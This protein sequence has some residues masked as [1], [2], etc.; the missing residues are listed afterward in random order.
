MEEDGYI[1]VEQRQKAEEELDQVQ[2]AARTS[3]FAAPHFV[4]FVK[5]ILVD[6]Y[7]EEMVENG[8][9]KVT[10][11][12]DLDLQ[13]EAEKIVAEE[14]EKVV[15]LN[16][17]NGAVIVLEPESGE[18]LAM[19]G[20]RDYNEPNF[21]KVNVVTQGLRQPGSAIK[22]LLMYCSEKGYTPPIFLDTRTEFTLRKTYI[23]V[24][25]D[26]KYHGRF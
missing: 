15:D 14:I 5:Q 11:T 24:N 8:G 21:G 4:M 2:F 18:I 12:L 20:S 16:I 9:L 10:T 7:G 22:R 3:D 13:Q 17:T 19:V 1:T 25:Y 23:P 26:G 6:R